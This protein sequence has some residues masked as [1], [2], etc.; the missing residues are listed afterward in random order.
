MNPVKLAIDDLREKRLWPVAL[1]LAALLVAVPLLLSKPGSTKAVASLAAPAGSTGAAAGPL[2]PGIPI[3]SVDN[4]PAH[5]R[6]NGAPHDPFAQQSSASGTL[7]SGAGVATTASSALAH[8]TGNSGGGSSSTPSGSSGATKSS[9][10]GSTSG[11]ASTK[12]TGTA[13]SPSTT[14]T[15]TTTPTP[16]PKPG[17]PP[18]SVLAAKETYHVALAMTNA[19]GGLD[20][21][22][23]LERLSVL[24]GK[25]LPL[26]V[27]LGVLKGGRRVL[28]ALQPGAVVSGPGSCTPGPVDCEVLS[29]ARDQIE[30]LGVQSGTGVVPVTMFA[31]TKIKVDRH[32]SVAAARK[33]R[34]QVSAAGRALLSSSPLSALSLFQYKPNLGSVVSLQ[35]L[36]VGGST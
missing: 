14:T 22:D 1:A 13:T 20:T 7:P 21:L 16:T 30:N 29:L 17:P 26:M 18:V 23:P 3:V 31:V 28:F 9:S 35:N 33:A 2:S 6:L 34:S 24:P 10:A 19:N 12:S 36:K 32:K 15:T 8:A 4:T 27:E 11:G 5:S 25:Q